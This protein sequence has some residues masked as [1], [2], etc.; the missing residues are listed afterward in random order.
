MTLD[1]KEKMT[2]WRQNAPAFIATG[3]VKPI[4]DTHQEAFSEAE[5]VLLSLGYGVDEIWKSFQSQERDEAALPKGA[6]EEI[7]RQS[8]QWLASRV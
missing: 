3:S 8:L 5:A 2:Q 1:L 4:S 7:L 6:S